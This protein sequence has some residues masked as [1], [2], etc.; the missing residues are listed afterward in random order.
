MR[1]SFTDLLVLALYFISQIAIGLWVGRKNKS[2]EQYFLGG[3]SFSGLVIGISFIG[4]VISSVT[5]MA[6]PADAFKT[7]WYRFIP[8]FAFPV[9]TLLAAWLL[10]P[11]FRRGTLTSAYQ[12]LALRFGGSI[13]AYASVVFITTQVLRTSMIAYLLSLLVGEITGWGFTG[14]LLLVVGVTAIYTVKGGLNAVIWTDVIQAIVLLVGAF[15]CIAV[16]IAHTPGGLPGVFSEGIAHH[17]FSFYDLD[18]V[19]GQLVPTKWFG[20]FGEKTVLMVFLVGLM[21][22][23]NLQFDQSTVQRWCSAR[24]AHDA[25][26]SMYILGLGCLPIWG[27]F[28]FLGV[29]LYVYFLHTPDPVAE[30]ILGGLHKAERIMPHFIMHYLPAGIVGLVIAGALAAAMSTLSACINV[31]SM[32]AVDDIYRKYINPGAS[33]RRRLR[34]GKLISLAVSLLM[35][36][37]ALLIHTL[38]VVTLADF[39]L[40][41]GTL[42]TIGVPAIFIAG[43]FTRRVDTAAIWTG[44]IVALAFMLWVMLGNAGQLPA[45]ISVRIPPYYISILGNLIALAVALPLSLLLRPRPRDLTNLT[46]WNQT[47]AS[48]E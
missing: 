38:D 42:I 21:Q 19:T 22:Y 14:S 36:A 11:F 17:K 29:C 15:A 41:A 48:L 35:I 23:L 33:D 34:L 43:M 31:S 24:T 18:T 6:T 46:V 13:S 37:G 10:V 7:A 4:S 9:V 8:N 3:K 26:K 5:F 39:M 12:Y 1:L 30:G 25:R 20:G 40:A 16:A 28:Q 47:S 45:C 27:L 32:V 2:T 44:V